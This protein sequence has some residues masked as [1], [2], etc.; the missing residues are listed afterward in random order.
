MVL[1]I[2]DTRICMLMTWAILYNYYAI[3]SR[4][5]TFDNTTVDRTMCH[6]AEPYQQAGISSGI[7]DLSS[8]NCLFLLANTLTFWNFLSI[9]S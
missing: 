3:L 4:D 5:N 6:G 9:D 8:V 1:Y 7:F 2:S